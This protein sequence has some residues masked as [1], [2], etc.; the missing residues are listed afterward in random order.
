MTADRA[1]LQRPAIHHNLARLIGRPLQ[2]GSQRHL[3]A[4]PGHV[5]MRHVLDAKGDSH[6]CVRTLQSDPIDGI[7][8]RFGEEVGLARRLWRM[9][10]MAG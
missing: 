1:M 8:D 2:S 6:K 10:T 5:E 9:S 4:G 7:V 3:L